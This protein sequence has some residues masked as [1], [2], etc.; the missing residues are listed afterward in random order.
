MLARR[1]HQQL[2]THQKKVWDLAREDHDVLITSATASGKTLACYLPILNH[3]IRNS[4]ACVL[5]L[6]PTKALAQDQCLKLKQWAE[7][8]PESAGLGPTQ[9]E[10]YDGDTPREAR[11]TIRNRVRIMISNPGMLNRSLLPFHRHTW[12]EFLSSLAFVFVDEIHIYRG[13]FGR[14]V[15]NVCLGLERL[16]DIH[17]PQRKA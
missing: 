11:R 1:G 14:H 7:D 8:L 16:L 17:Q 15:A 6:A 13:I 12:K 9:I 10:T 5:Y 4:Q 2:C 3:L